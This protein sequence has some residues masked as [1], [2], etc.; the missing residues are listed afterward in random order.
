MREDA[1]FFNI[2]VFY[3]IMQKKY[4]KYVIDQI[5]N[6]NSEELSLDLIEKLVRFICNTKGPGAILIFLPG[7]MD[8]SKLNRI[9]VDSGYYP[10]RKSLYY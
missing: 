6:F 4:P 2:N 3:M 1:L 10:N 8:I 5:R 7:M 9:L